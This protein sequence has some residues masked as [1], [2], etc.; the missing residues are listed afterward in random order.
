MTA[1]LSRL[2]VPLILPALVLASWEAAARLG[3]LNAFLLPGPGAVLAAGV[4]LARSGDL[5][6]DAAASFSRVLIGFLLSSALALPTAAALV[7][8]RLAGDLLL[9]P[10]NFLRATPPLALLPL[11]VLW[12][13]IGEGAKWIVVVL[14]SF[15]PILLNTITGLRA[16]SPQHRELA[17]T[18][19]LTRAETL[20]FIVIPSALPVVVAGLRL[21]F[22]YCW[23]AM[24]GAELLATSAG[25]GFR[26]MDA[27][28]I[29]RSDIVYAGIFVLAGLG[30]LADRVFLTAARGLAGGADVGD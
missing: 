6:R 11:L 26:I 5:A 23:R 24:V 18:L 17:R 3:A 13:G 28:S 12:F 25:L 10:L 2:L 29:A 21:G 4:E 27:Q 14:A 30:F 16:V 22:G 15:F 19:E 9:V 7:R 8:W 1:R 20:R